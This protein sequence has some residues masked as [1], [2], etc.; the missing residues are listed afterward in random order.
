M[1]NN[2]Q[3]NTQCLIQLRWEVIGTTDGIFPTGFG[4]VIATGMLIK[5]N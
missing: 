5:Q 2:P 1:Y 3:Y 4:D